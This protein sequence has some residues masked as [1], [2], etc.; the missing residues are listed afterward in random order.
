MQRLCRSSCHRYGMSHQMN[1]VINPSKGVVPSAERPGFIR[2]TPIR[3]WRMTDIKEPPLDCK[4]LEK[5][6]TLLLLEDPWVSKSS[7]KDSF[8]E[9]VPKSYGMSFASVEVSW[10]EGGV[11]GAIQELKQDLSQVPDA[12]LVARGPFSCWS[13][14]FYLES[15][16]LLGLI[17]VDPIQFDEE[18]PV[19]TEKFFADGWGFQVHENPT[20]KLLLEESQTRTLRLEENAVPMSIYQTST[21]L[22]ATEASKLV[23]AR[24]SHTDGPYGILSSK[25]IENA[26]PDVVLEEINEWVDTIL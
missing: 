19:A 26:D 20:L 24:H 7:W 4:V 5:P 17:M 1:R 2:T 22:V 12:L 25:L 21:G 3:R 18:D 6:C 16:P 8:A 10:E 15:F 9:Q 11:E 14:A 23:A 13:A